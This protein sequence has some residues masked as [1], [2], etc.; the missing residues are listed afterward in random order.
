MAAMTAACARLTDR[1]VIRVSGL[2]ARAF[3]NRLLTQEVETLADG[4]LRYGALLTPQGRVLHDIFLWGE[5]DG[6]RLDVHADARDD[7]LRR[8]AMFRLRAAVE[9]AP[10]DTPVR[11]LWGPVDRDT[12]GWRADSRLSDMGLRTLGDAEA[13]GAPSADLAA[14]TRHRFALGVAEA[15]ADG[16]SDKAYA[17]EADLDLLGGVDFSKGCFVGQETTSRMKRRGGV[18]SRVLPLRFEGEAPAQGAEVLAGDLRAGE[19]TA[20]CDHLALALLRLDRCGGAMMA[21]GR[22]A[23]LCRPAWLPAEALASPSAAAAPA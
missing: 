1:A 7:L 12:S 22:A 13:N 23:V 11:A 3:L 6:V 8:L 19:I 10:E 2:E 18:R 17:T 5:A 9:I 4:E 14:Y 15:T 21:D 16:L 20:R